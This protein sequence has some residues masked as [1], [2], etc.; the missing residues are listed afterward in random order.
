V[1][2]P[3]DAGPAS[4]RAVGWFAILAVLVAWLAAG[5][6]GGLLVSGV[7]ESSEDFDDAR[8]V[9]LGE[10][11]PEVASLLLIVAVVG[12][13]HWWRPVLHEELTA[14]RWAV[15]FPVGLVLVS[16]LVLDTQRVRDAGPA[17][18]GAL[19]ATTLLIAAS[20]ELTF[21]GFVLVALRDRHRELTAALV[22]TLL[23]AGAHL[24]GGGLTN[25]G[26]GVLTLLAGFVFY[27]ARRV[28]RTIVAAVVLH[29]WWDVTVFSALLG[30]GA[31]DPALLFE[32]SLALLVLAAA[33]LA[34]YRLW[35]PRSV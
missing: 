7:A 20:E 9:L 19:A 15:V 11:L 25:I 5:V 35:Q 4:R 28:S 34:T 6:V 3:T 12:A 27:V 23:F 29:A 8:A 24:L 2:T 14:R 17:L 32:A 13:L 18:V 1:S 31:S 33:A 21:R 10:A 26:Q 22:S 30:P 16:L